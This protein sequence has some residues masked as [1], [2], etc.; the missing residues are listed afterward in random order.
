MHQR[1][2]TREIELT[3]DVTVGRATKSHHPQISRT[4]VD[5]H[6][7]D[8]PFDVPAPSAANCAYIPK[9]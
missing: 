6:Q 2:C 1:F 3:T 8:A 7:N 5:A 4:T 9:V